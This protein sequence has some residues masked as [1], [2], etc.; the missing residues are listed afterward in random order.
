MQQEK[1]EQQ[2]SDGFTGQIIGACIEVHRHLGPGLLESAYELCLCH[3]LELRAVRFV[4]QQVI[5]LNYKGLR[6]ACGYRADLIVDSRLLVEIKA[7]EKVLPVHKAQVIAYLKAIGLRTGLL[8]NFNV[9]MLKQDLH[10]L[11]NPTLSS[12]SA[13]RLSPVSLPSGSVERSG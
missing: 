11:I 12:G 4:R 10:R 9:P 7:I 3:E 8:V 1:A 13:T 6:L 2:R 5:A